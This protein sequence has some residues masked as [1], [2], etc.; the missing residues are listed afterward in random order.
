MKDD[1]FTKLFKYM[2]AEFKKINNRI[3]QTATKLDTLTQT[4]DL[5]TK[6]ADD[7]MQEMITLT[8][9][10]VKSTY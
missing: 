3:E 7:R 8:H 1:K 10:G 4:L 6:K 2:Q 5:Y 9:N